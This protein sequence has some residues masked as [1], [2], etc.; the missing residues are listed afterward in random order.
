[1]TSSKF[2]ESHSPSHS[3]LLT[4]STMLKKNKKTKKQ[5][6]QKKNRNIVLRYAME[7]FFFKLFP[8]IHF[9]L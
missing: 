6:K 2:D 3:P 9:G 1:M 4:L 7:K 5:K 8:T